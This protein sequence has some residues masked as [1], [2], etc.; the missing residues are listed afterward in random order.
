[1]KV[2]VKLY[3]SKVLSNG[4]NP[5]V[6]ELSH[7][8]KRKIIST[9]ESAKPSNWLASGK[10]GSRD[11]RNIEK[12]KVIKDVYDTLY[13]RCD[14]CWNKLKKYD[15]DL[16][17]DINKPILKEEEEPN[18]IEDDIKITD[19]YQ[20]IDYKAQ[21]QKASSLKNYKQLKNYLISTYG[22]S[23]PMSVINQ[24]WVDVF[25][26]NLAE[27]KSKAQQAK[28]S[29]Y[30][31]IVF[32][33]GRDNDLIANKKVNVDKKRTVYK[34]QGKKA[35]S[36]IALKT[37]YNHLTAVL[38]SHTPERDYKLTYMMHNVCNGIMIYMLDYFFQ[39]LA[40]VDLANI[41]MGDLE[42]KSSLKEKTK[43]MQPNEIINQFKGLTREEQKNKLKEMNDNDIKYITLPNGLFRKKTSSEAQI[44][45][46]LT[47]ELKQILDF[48]RYKKDGTLKDKDDYLINFLSK[49]KQRTAKQQVERVANCGYFLK[50]AML[51]EFEKLDIANNI[52][53]EFREMS[54]YTMRHTY[55]TVGLRIGINKEQLAN[56]A[57]H[58]VNEQ[59]TYFDGFFEHQLLANNLKIYQSLASK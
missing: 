55:I 17:C 20:L 50:S 25:Q 37:L 44:V 39:G 41:K 1:M 36:P 49:D 4:E 29:K 59:A 47:Q 19:F 38:M 27:N 51:K 22:D 11:A 56:M 7:S 40:P 34:V 5:I 48:Y 15:F 33:F 16:I 45:I 8:K 31:M 28:L 53:E 32:N 18:Y 6:V 9:G 54:L 13:N 35:L 30:F 3:K 12:N 46:P 2:T 26:S 43:N 24:R 52:L 58:S 57:G 21:T 42:I 14:E 23:L 10:V